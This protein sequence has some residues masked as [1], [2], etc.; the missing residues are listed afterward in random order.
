MTHVNVWRRGLLYKVEL[1]DCDDIEIVLDTLLELHILMD[2]DLLCWK[3]RTGW[4]IKQ[5][6]I[7]YFIGLQT[8]T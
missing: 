8:F 2:D 7:Y 6:G 3:A 5:Q 1:G 4:I